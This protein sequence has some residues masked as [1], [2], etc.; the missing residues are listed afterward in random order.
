MGT[1][2]TFESIVKVCVS[3]LDKARVEVIEALSAAWPAFSMGF[4]RSQFA[5]DS[6]TVFSLTDAEIRDTKKS[7]NTINEQVERSI[8]DD[9]TALLSQPT[10]NLHNKS[11]FKSETDQRLGDFLAQPL[12]DLNKILDRLDFE[13]APSPP[14]LVTDAIGSRED[15]LGRR[16]H[17]AIGAYTS[18]DE[19]VE[20][21]RKDH[22]KAL[23]DEAN[24]R[25]C[26]HWDSV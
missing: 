22:A 25:A 24:A 20:Q 4:V 14:S 19:R 13:P 12:A 5:D 2:G 21:A 15:Y 9:L 16:Y 7:I 17:K 11:P 8:R 26:A 6:G 3:Q 10:P 23:A 18:I 1:S